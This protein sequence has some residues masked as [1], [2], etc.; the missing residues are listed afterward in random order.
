MAFFKQTKNS[1]TIMAVTLSSYAGGGHHTCHDLHMADVRCLSVC[2]S[3]FNQSNAKEGRRSHN[4]DGLSCNFVPSLIYGIM[5]MNWV[6][7]FDCD[8]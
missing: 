6:A 5:H 3:S 8:D 2:H 1:S 4:K 7:D